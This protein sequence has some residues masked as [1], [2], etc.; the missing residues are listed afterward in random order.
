MTFVFSIVV[1]FIDYYCEEVHVSNKFSL[2]TITVRGV[3]NEHC[4]AYCPFSL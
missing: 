1:F 3:S 4:I 2:L